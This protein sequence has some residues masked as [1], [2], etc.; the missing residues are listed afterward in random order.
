MA[1][2]IHGFPKR[3]GEIPPGNLA[4]NITRENVETAIEGSHDLLGRHGI[5]GEKRRGRTLRVTNSMFFF[6]FLFLHFR[7]LDRHVIG[8]W[9]IS[10]WRAIVLIYLRR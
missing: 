7:L 4:T 8:H 1:S 2:I 6:L 10:A 3:F 9:G 5:G